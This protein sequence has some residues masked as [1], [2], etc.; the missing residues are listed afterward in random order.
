MPHIEKSENRQ[1]KL[2]GWIKK[3]IWK[4]AKNLQSFKRFLNVDLTAKKREVI[5]S[6]INA[7]VAPVDENLHKSLEKMKLADEN[8]S[9]III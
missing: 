4:S 2:L 9:K 8:L 5:E 6:K 3:P 7:E 1:R